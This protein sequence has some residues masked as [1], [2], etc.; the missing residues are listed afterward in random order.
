V[1][2]SPHFTLHEMV[3]SQEAERNGID[4]T[5]APRIVENLQFLAENLER[6]RALLKC[7][8]RTSSGFRCQ[9]LNDAIGGSQTSQ[10]RFGLAW[11][12]SAPG[13]GS[14]AEVVAAIAA[15]DIEFDQLI[16]EYSWVHISF[17]RNNPRRMIGVKRAGKDIVW[18]SGSR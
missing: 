8:M 11:D 9:R 10:H 14:P 16:D 6:V 3:F 15:S 5:P 1:N 17:V 18:Q 13:F 4:N 7:P 2:L 12:G